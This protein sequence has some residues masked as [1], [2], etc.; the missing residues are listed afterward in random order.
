MDLRRDLPVG[1]HDVDIIVQVKPRRQLLAAP[2]RLR[3]TA[4]LA[5]VSSE[6]NTVFASTTSSSM[7]PRR[8]ANR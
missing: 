5:S 4:K 8:R 6:N 1:W 3:S 2:A 7:T